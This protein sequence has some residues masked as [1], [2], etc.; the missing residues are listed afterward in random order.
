MLPFALKIVW[1]V[2]AVLGTIIC[3]AMLSAFGAAVGSR[4]AP[5]CYCLA[6]TVLEGMF[7]LG[8]IWRMDPF[9]MPRAFCIAQ[10]ILMEVS[11]FCVAGICMTFNLSTSLFVLKPKTWGNVDQCVWR[12]VFRLRANAQR[13]AFKWRTIYIFPLIVYPLFSS[14]VQ[15]ALI[16]KYN[17]IQPTDDMNC[18]ASDPLWIRLIGHASPAFVLL[19]PSLYLAVKSVIR[20]MR[21]LNHLERSRYDQDTMTPR[22]IRRERH[23]EH[24]SYKQRTPAAIHPPMVDDSP[25]TSPEPEPISPAFPLR[26]ES[27][28]R[29]GLGFH[30][31]FFRPPSQA[32]S[33]P[34]RSLDASPHDDGRTSVAS[35]SFPTFA[36]TADKPGLYARHAPDESVNIDIGNMRSPWVDENSSAPTSHEGHETPQV[37]ELDVKDQEE[38]DDGV[39]RLS[40]RENTPS[41][42]LRPPPLNRSH[43]TAGRS[44]VA[45]IPHFTPA[46]QRLIVFQVAFVLALVLASVSSI[47]DLAKHR[48]APTPFATHHITLLI[49]AWA[50]AAV[51]GAHH[52][53]RPANTTDA[54]QAHC[55]ACGTGS[56]FG[57]DDRPQPNNG[58]RVG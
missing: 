18:D 5:L 56:R 34:P 43:I 52:H 1:L 3:W 27:A 21:T 41:R 39:Y 22:P 26:A 47:V 24:H 55:S 15:I 14:I 30:L 16:L 10:T 7:C 36:P 31:P 4:W 40:Y 37:L 49:A 9:L 19:V 51:F 44:H 38:D 28:P 35:S 8:M 46:I 11:N 50:P 25:P 53:R 57:K 2:L 54:Y 6:L 12:H 17:A 32:L 45:H 23:S 33:L 48:A 58:D 20:V 29:P 13:R 42:A